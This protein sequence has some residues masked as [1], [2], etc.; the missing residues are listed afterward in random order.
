M[1]SIKAYAAEI[2]DGID[3]S[4]STS[5]FS[6]AS[7]LNGDDALKSQRDLIKAKARIA[8]PNQIDLF[9]YDS[10]LASVGWNKNDDVFDPIETWL[11]RNSA[12][13]KPVNY[14]HDESDIIGHMVDTIVLSDG[15]VVPND[16][17]VDEIPEKFDVLTASVLY[18]HWETEDLKQRIA[19]I[20]E[21]IDNGELYVSMECLFPNFDYAL[22]YTDG[23]Q[24]VVQ[25]NEDTA[26][27]TK[28][29][30]C[31]GGSGVWKDARIGRVLRNIIFSAK[32]IVNK[33][34]NSR[35]II[36]N[37]DK[38]QPFFVSKSKELTKLG[39]NKM[40]EILEKQVEELKKTLASVQEEN[41]K[42]VD[43]EK[44]G[45]A[46]AKAALETQLA[47]VKAD[48]QK[49]VASLNSVISEKD[50][51]ISTLNSLVEEKDKTILAKD[52]EI[53]AKADCMEDMKKAEMKMKRKAKL[54][55]AGLTEAEADSTVD[56]WSNASDEQ[57]DEVV[58][59]Y[60]KEKTPDTSIATAAEIDKAKVEKDA[61]MN[62]TQASETLSKAKAYFAKLLVKEKK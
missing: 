31:Y 22:M 8:N 41:K 49:Q 29:L 9:Y 18:T 54:T 62:A 19:K 6:F 20:I 37:T 58:K 13:D 35:S 32:G 21:Q 24:K 52:A 28:Y 30:R 34:A 3:L 42:L 61:E 26:F 55:S 15:N 40:S 46:Q 12:A 4:N 27:L 16:I 14:Q 57:F 36:L 43:K 10:I 45:I 53:K 59:L 38:Y 51:K 50:N 23:S 7:S 1:G 39:D 44:D 11:A 47:E 2:K 33:P 25:R 5:Y 17:N 56:K 48:L 60:T